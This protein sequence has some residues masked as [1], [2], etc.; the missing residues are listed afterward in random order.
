MLLSASN[1]GVPLIASAHA[2]N[3]NELLSRSNIKL[4]HEQAVFDMYVKIERENER[5]GINK[6]T[7]YRRAEIT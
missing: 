3:I 2:K 6:Y 4:L 5:R 7:F 1:A